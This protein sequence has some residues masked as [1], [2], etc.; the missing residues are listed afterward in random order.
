TITG[1]N[2]G[3]NSSSTVTIT[4]VPPPPPVITYP[5]PQVYTTLDAIAPLVPTNTG[6]AA[7]GYIIDKP[8]PAGL[9]LDPLTGTISGI[10]TAVS[11][12]T[13]YTITANNAGGTGSFTVN[14]TVIAK[15][16][17]TQTITFAPLP[18]KTYGDVDFV[19][20]ATSTNS[21]IPITYTSNNTAVAIF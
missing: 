15:I 14:I 17:P 5:T 1:Y 10:P 20:G 13:D 18:T 11:P 2:T 9:T 3:G 16:L 19:P 4:T 21:T 7:E 8:L 6:G 12:A